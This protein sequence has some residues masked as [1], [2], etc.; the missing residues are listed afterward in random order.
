MSGFSFLLVEVD[1]P[2]CAAPANLFL[3]HPSMRTGIRLVWFNW[4]G[5]TAL[6]ELLWLVSMLHWFPFS[7][8]TRP[9]NRFAS[10]C[11]S[12]LALRP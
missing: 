4:T 3:R 1:E 6:N 2:L 7:R 12:R 5:K 10:R 8:T 9:P 11:A